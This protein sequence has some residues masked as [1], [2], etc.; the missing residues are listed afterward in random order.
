VPLSAVDSLDNFQYLRF[1]V[2]F[3]VS[4]LQEFTDPLPKIRQITIPVDAGQ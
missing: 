4:P 3:T 2:F 1:R